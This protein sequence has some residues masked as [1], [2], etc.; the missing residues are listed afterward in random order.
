MGQ[1]ICIMKVDQTN[2]IANKKEAHMDWNNNGK[3]DLEDQFIDYTIIN[4]VHKEDSSP[5][6]SSSDWWLYVLFF[7]VICVCPPIG[8]LIFFGVLIFNK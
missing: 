3:Y 6:K 1:F 2:E 4:S 7:I 8:A 5:Y